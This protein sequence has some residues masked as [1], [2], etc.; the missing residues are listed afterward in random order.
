METVHLKV[1]FINF[2]K[3]SAKR[4]PFFV[5]ECF[6]FCLLHSDKIFLFLLPQTLNYGAKCYLHTLLRKKTRIIHTYKQ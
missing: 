3:N 5:P 1:N 6:A 4:H 2:L